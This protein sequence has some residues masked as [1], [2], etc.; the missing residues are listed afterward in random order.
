MKYKVGD[1]VL[2][3]EFNAFGFRQIKKYNCD[4]ELYTVNNDFFGCN[5]FYEY[6]IASK[7]NNLLKWAYL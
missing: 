1:I 5:V 3:V 6:E 4:S 2:L 7:A